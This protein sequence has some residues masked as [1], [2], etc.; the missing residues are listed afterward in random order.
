MSGLMGMM[1]AMMGSGGGDDFSK[2]FQGM[3]S[4]GKGVP[5]QKGTK[6]VFNESALKKIAKAKKLKNKLR[7][8]KLK[9]ANEAV[10]KV[11]ASNDA[12]AS[13]EEN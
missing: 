4:G 5:K 6:P 7:E 9:E 2:M 3:A 11:E 1:S 10:T 13:S 12:G 8:K